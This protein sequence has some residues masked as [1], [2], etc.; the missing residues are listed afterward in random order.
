MG[1]YRKVAIS[2]WSCWGE[3]G[4]E[5]V[6]RVVGVENP[7]QTGPKIPSPLTAREKLSHCGMN[8]G[9]VRKR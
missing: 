3:C 6:P 5:G 1:E 4:G 9:S 7:P 2:R 8:Y